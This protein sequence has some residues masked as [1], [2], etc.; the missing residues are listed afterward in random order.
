MRRLSVAFPLLLALLLGLAPAAR[1]QDATPAAEEEGFPLPEGVSGAFLAYAPATDLPGVG[2][3]A[4][5]RLTFEP[6]A[7]YP[8]DPNDPSTAL[9]VVE[10]G[11]LTFELDAAVTVVRAPEEGQ[12]PTDY[13]EVAA[14]EGFTLAEG[15]STL[16]PGN[17]AGEA[18]NDG[19]GEAV[20]L[21]SN[22]APSGGG[23]SAAGNAATPAAGNDVGAVEIVDFAFAPDPLEI[24]VG[25]TV[26]WTNRDAAPHTATADDGSFDSGTLAMGDSFSFTFETPGTYTYI[27][28]IHPQMA[29]T[30]VVT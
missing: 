14:G 27:C 29:G 3:L 9:V 2:E 11:E 12:F 15:D 24:A 21:I 26:T 18:R 19:D 23:V 6:G 16:V 17:V 7:A 28:T 5:F 30:I 20:L 8:L 1:A 10:Q 13:E 4:L 22:V 25:E